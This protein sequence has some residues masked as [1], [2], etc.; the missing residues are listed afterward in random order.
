M[1]V[2][3]IN[4]TNYRG[5]RD[6]QEIPLSRFSSMIG[7]NDSGKSI[8]LNALATFLDSKMYLITESDFNE[9]TEKIIIECKFFDDVLKDKLAFQ[10][11]SKIKKS[12]GL[13]F[14]L[15]DLII[16]NTISIQK[17]TSK[18]GKSFEEINLLF[19]DYSHDD[20]S[21][22]YYKNDEELTDILKRYSIVI[23]VKGKGRNSKLEKIEHIK[24][25]CE[26]NNVEREFKYIPDEYKIDSL[27]P[28]VELFESDYGLEADTNFKSNSVSEIQEFFTEETRDDQSRL[29]K[30]Q[31][32]IQSE[33][34][35]E[36]LSI[37]EY[38]TDYTVGLHDIQISPIIDWKSA[39]KGVNVSFQFDGDV[40]PIP[41]T[42]KGTGY[43]RLFMVARFR[44]L[45]E[46]SKG[47]AIIYLIEEPETFL[48][49]S[50]QE[51]LLNSLIELSSENQIL[52]T[53]HS[54]VFVG[55]T[56]YN[57]VILCKKSDQSIYSHA[58]TT[59]E[60]EFIHN[61]I[62]DLG[63]K[64][65][66]N[67]VDSFEKIL[68]VE[69][70]NDALF[71]H[72]ISLKVLGVGLLDNERILVLPG[73]GDSIDSFVNIEYF[74]RS[75][76]D[77]FLIIDS[78]KQNTEKVQQKQ[79]DRQIKFCH[80]KKSLAYILK[81]SCIEN[82]YHPRVIE[83]LYSLPA[84]SLEYFKD[85]ENVKNTLNQYKERQRDAGINIQFSTKNNIDV[86]ENMGK[87]EWE[88]VI[89]DELVYF[90]KEIVQ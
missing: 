55:H 57:S 9:N 25:Y 81:K 90:L 45:A 76:R 72:H 39:I 69:S 88:E 38:M 65:Y 58:E 17:I 42:H 53:T 11:K 31:N 35:K 82:Y 86:F 14:F 5:I 21:F 74:E 71:Y 3:A 1:I 37:K 73:G 27:L 62:E 43:R 47:K 13:D 23:P 46:K 79:R 41:M 18:I 2:Q 32:D 61:I 87:E 75:N 66:F 51:D 29:N 12:D 19:Y 16:G 56:E 89:E 36:A 26:D 80:R 85:D 44:Y 60:T 8:V 28:A 78:D 4:I 52:I 34:N 59:G 77:L 10:I 68:F 83:S 33:M 24:K 50:A 20:F 7:K 40:K 67:L 70:N 30:V 15:D 84:Q 48:H 22:L 6:T 63:I 49:P 64:P 54:P